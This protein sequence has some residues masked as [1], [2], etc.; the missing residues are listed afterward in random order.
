MTFRHIILEFSMWY[1]SCFYLTRN[2]YIIEYAESLLHCFAT[3][4][5]K[6]KFASFSQNKSRTHHKRIFACDVSDIFINFGQISPIS[7]L[8]GSRLYIHYKY[9]LM[10]QLS[11]AWVYP[12]QK[13]LHNFYYVVRKFFAKSIVSHLSCFV[14]TIP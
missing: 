7:L 9:Y 1:C 2:N 5:K 11:R 4:P 6:A 3:S 12:A 10:D 13:I 8:Y 14:N